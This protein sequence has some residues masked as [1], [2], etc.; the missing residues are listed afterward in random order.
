[1]NIEAKRGTI[2]LARKLCAEIEG[3]KEGESVEKGREYSSRDAA[4][5][6]SAEVERLRELLSPVSDKYIIVRN[7][8]LDILQKT[9]NNLIKEGYLP[10]GGIAITSYITGRDNDTYNYEHVQAMIKGESD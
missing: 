5:I 6:L 3:A 1:M 9:V 8:D 10:Q 7:E 4:E 2:Y